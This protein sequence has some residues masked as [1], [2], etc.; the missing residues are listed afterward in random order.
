[1]QVTVNVVTVPKI[2]IDSYLESLQECIGPILQEED[3]PAKTQYSILSAAVAAC[4]KSVC[5]KH[6]KDLEAAGLYEGVTSID[7]PTFKWTKATRL[8][9]AVDMITPCI[10]KSLAEEMIVEKRDLSR[11]YDFLEAWHSIWVNKSTGEQF[12]GLD[13]P[14]VRRLEEHVLGIAEANIRMMLGET[15]TNILRVLNNV[16]DAVESGVDTPLDTLEADLDI[17][18]PTPVIYL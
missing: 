5:V 10:A 14:S 3:L 13:S 6:V 12:D 1:M 4:N 15:P 7:Y 2:V 9:Y 16:K 8:L 17:L 18:V 11:Y